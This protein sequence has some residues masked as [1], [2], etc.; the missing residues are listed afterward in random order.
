MRK[1]IIEKRNLIEQWIAEGLPKSE[2]ALR[3]QCKQ[4]TLNSYLSKMSISYAG[5]QNKKGQHKGSNVYRDSSYYTYKD[6]PAIPSSRLREKLIKDGIKQDAC[7]YC[8]Q[9]HWLGKKLPLELHHL[10]GNHFNNEL[11]NLRIICP[12]CHAVSAPNSGAAVG[13]YNN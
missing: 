9:S 2:I 11:S 6:A 1:D 3:L 4:E 10:D 7:E 8:G 12:N 5:Q 13:N